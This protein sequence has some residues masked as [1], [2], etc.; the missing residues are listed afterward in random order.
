M[1]DS[2][3]VRLAF[4]IRTDDSN[5][6]IYRFNMPVEIIEIRPQHNID[7]VD[8]TSFYIRIPNHLRG[9]LKYQIYICNMN[10]DRV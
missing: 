3:L 4:F 5:D 8:Y 7:I 10:G 9:V 1:S 6:T 2:P